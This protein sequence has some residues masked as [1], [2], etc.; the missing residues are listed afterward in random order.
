MAKKTNRPQYLKGATTM[1]ILVALDERPMHG[2]ELVQHLEERT[3]GLFEFKQGTIYPL[4]YSLED[5]GWLSS[6]IRKA[7]SGRECKVYSTT[8]KGRAAKTDQVDEWRL[9]L[10]GVNAAIGSQ[11]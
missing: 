5:K 4:L 8:A 10:R 2:Y 9:F 7:D 1:L 3:K 6:K 11:P